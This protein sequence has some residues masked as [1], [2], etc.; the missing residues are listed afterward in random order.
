MGTP[1]TLKLLR[2]RT[3]VI[4]GCLRS[5][6]QALAEVATRLPQPFTIPD[7]AVAACR[8]F[9]TKFSL[10]GYP[11]VPDSNVVVCLLCGKRGLVRRGVLV[12]VAGGRLCLKSRVMEATKAG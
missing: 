7:L 6:Y 3:E 12:R 10:K 11:G 8:E 1:A 4:R 5:K 2:E 9:P